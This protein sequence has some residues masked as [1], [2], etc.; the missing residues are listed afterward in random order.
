MDFEPTI[1]HPIV[2]AILKTLQLACLRP[3]VEI[4]AEE[5]LKPPQG[6]VP[7]TGTQFTNRAV[8]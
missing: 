6:R 5:L 4:R 8:T 2:F 3:L 7:R 1:K